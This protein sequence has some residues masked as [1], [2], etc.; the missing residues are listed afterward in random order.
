MYKSAEL[1]GTSI[2]IKNEKGGYEIIEDFDFD[3]AVEDPS[4]ISDCVGLLGEKL[5]KKTVKTVKEAKSLLWNNRDKV[6][7]MDTL[8]N[9]V[10][11]SHDQSTP[12]EL[13]KI[14]AI[15]IENSYTRGVPYTRGDYSHPILSIAITFAN[16][17]NPDVDIDAI[18]NKVVFGYHKSITLSN[19]NYVYCKD[20]EDLL[21]KFCSAI[22]KINPDLVTGYNSSQHDIPYILS[23]MDAFKININKLS[24]LYGL[25]DKKKKLVYYN[26][27]FGTLKVAGWTHIDY[28][29]L[30]QKYAK[31][32]LPNYKLDSVAKFEI[33]RQKVDYSE[34]EDLLDL[35]EKNPTKFYEYN[36]DDCTL[37]LLIDR[38]KKFLRLAAT[39]S[40]IGRI[41]IGDYDSQIAF[42][43][44]FVWRLA[45]ERNK[46]IPPNIK[47]ERVEFKGAF[48]KKTITG[49]HRLLATFDA[50]S[51]YP[52]IMRALNI[53]VETYLGKGP[54]IPGASYAPNGAR[55]RTDFE[56]IMKIAVT[57]MFNL[58]KS[59]KAKM[60]ELER[61]A[62]ETLI[63][64]TDDIE[65]LDIY[66]LVYKLA[67]N[68]LY[69]IHGSEFWRYYNVDIA[70]AI[71]S[72]GALLNKHVA[73]R[74]NNFVNGAEQSNEYLDRLD[75]PDELID[76]LD[77]IISMDTD[78]VYVKL[79]KTVKQVPGENVI[80]TLDRFVE[81][82]INP[83]L[84]SW[85]SELGQQLNYTEN[86]FN[87]KREALASAG[88]WRAKK[89]YAML[90]EDMEHVR[91]KSPK[92]KVA[93][94][95]Y[96]KVSTPDWSKERLKQIYMDILTF[97]DPGP[98]YN[99]SKNEFMKLD[100]RAL[101]K[102][103]RV[104]G[105]EKYQSDLAGA[106]QVVKGALAYND[107][108][109]SNNLS[110][111]MIQS[112]DIVIW[113]YLKMP[114]PFKSESISFF[115]DSPIDTLNIDEFIDLNK[116]FDVAY[117]SAAETISAAAG[118]DVTK[119]TNRLSRFLQ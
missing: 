107:Y 34:Y 74:L 114:N 95:E 10:L 14:A 65:T 3:F 44:S 71:T 54:K 40:M 43:D 112:G 7:G 105:L 24:P 35:Y 19:A 5:S 61:L 42:W 18:K 97:K 51:L 66:Q 45:K 83:L 15:D 60:K 29:P 52:S 72:A 23:R 46:Y 69:G 119:K 88:V 21:E 20:E 27:G 64:Y 100:L 76:E 104:N 111:D 80:D 90:V 93:G 68:S 99:K 63:N 55:F 79:D 41:R 11:Y 67:I 9:Q 59:T 118:F 110:T 33:D 26:Q 17:G 2:F 12:W 81:E 47:K 36:S 106:S 50:E 113:A 22:R 38:K 87:Y 4:A 13:F 109:S 31:D 117:G 62:I 92:L 49:L 103:Q 78:S 85:T 116:M 75:Y 25:V 101:A 48:V 115:Y 108:V 32:R 70:E 77:N 30:Y 57:T 89:N 86:T 73:F 1:I 37:L 39:I 91:Y 28:M 53:S 96:V 84:T 94:L 56:G 8:L 58:R 102:A 98:T 16:I 82:T 6:Y